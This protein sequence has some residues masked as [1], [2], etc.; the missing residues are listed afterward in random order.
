MVET[1]TVEEGY[2]IAHQHF[3]DNIDTHTTGRMSGGLHLHIPK[4][5]SWM[6]K[7]FEF[8]KENRFIV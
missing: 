5:K 1:E 8:L 7:I 2:R 3:I 4:K 6:R